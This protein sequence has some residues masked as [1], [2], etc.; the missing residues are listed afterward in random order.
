LAADPQVNINSTKD[1]GFSV[2]MQLCMQNRASYFQQCFEALLL[3]DG[4]DVSIQDGEKTNALHLICQFNGQRSLSNITK[5]VEKGIDPK[6]TDMFGYNALHC[7]CKLRCINFA[8]VVRYLIKTCGSDVNA[9]TND[10]ETPLTLFCRNALSYDVVEGIR[11]FVD[12]FKAD[13]NRLTLQGENAL[14]CLCQNPYV[15]ENGEKLVEGV[16]LLIANGLDINSKTI[17]GDSVLTSFIRCYNGP[18]LLE[19]VRILV[20]VLGMKPTEDALHCLFSNLKL[21]KSIKQLIGTARFLI[22]HGA[23]VNSKSDNKGNTPL[24]SLLSN[25]SLVISEP[26]IFIRFGS[27]CFVSS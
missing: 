16:R 24:L 7:Y 21:M 25:P 12:E 27:S 22:D 13:V 4:I 10:G 6:V 20:D 11:L 18:R 3:V 19:T 5:L 2:L 26:S 23:N 8:G 1:N 9:Q 15:C 17:K 14:H